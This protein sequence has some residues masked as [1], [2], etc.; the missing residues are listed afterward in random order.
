MPGAIKKQ[1]EIFKQSVNELQWLK[2]DGLPNIIRSK[3]KILSIAWT[4]VLLFSASTCVWLIMKTFEQYNAH[5]VTTSIRRINEER[6]VFPTIVLCNMNP[7]NTDYAASLFTNYNVTFDPQSDTF[8][9][10]ATLQEKIKQATGSYL[11]D[12]QVRNMSSFTNMLVNCYF[13]GISCFES[14]FDYLYHPYLSGC[15]IFNL[16]GTRTTSSS[17]IGNSL[18]VRLYTGVP[19]PIAASA[20]QRGFNVLF[21]NSSDYPYPISPNMMYLTP[22]VGIIYTVKRIIYH[23]HPAPYSSCTV[24]GDGT[25]VDGYEIDDRTLFNAVVETG[26]AYSQ[27]TCIIFCEQVKTIEWCGCLSPYIKYKMSDYQ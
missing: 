4:I 27:A 15:Y 10:F 21:F 25:I 7:F 8:T 11:T 6:A 2:V 12:Q 24:L 20:F 9:S 26:Y 14:D 23:Q 17:G 16:N 18:N 22:G 19:D 3:Y 13:Q 1:S 5:G